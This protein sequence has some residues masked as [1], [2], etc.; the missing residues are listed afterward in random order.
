MKVSELIKAL[1]ACPQTSDVYITASDEIL[2]YGFKVGAVLIDLLK[3]SSDKS[4]PVGKNV[5][6]VYEN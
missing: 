1:T 2:D 6:I 3:K 4:K 5:L